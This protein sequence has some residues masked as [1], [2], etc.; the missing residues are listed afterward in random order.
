M[1]QNRSNQAILIEW[2]GSI[3]SNKVFVLNFMPKTT[4]LSS[5]RHIWSQKIQIMINWSISRWKML[6]VRLPRAIFVRLKSTDNEVQC[7]DWKVSSGFGVVLDR[8]VYHNRSV[9][10]RDANVFSP[11]NQ[12]SKKQFRA[13]QNFT[14][15]YNSSIHYHQWF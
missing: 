8:L 5:L 4:N 1:N 9:I 14:Y 10:C 6:I 15:R 2:V 3:G 13:Q 7:D 12:I 11:E